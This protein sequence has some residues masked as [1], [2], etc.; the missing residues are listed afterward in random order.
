M[1]KGVK[2]KYKQYQY[3]KMLSG[4]TPIFSQF[5]DDIY[6][7]DIVKN[8]IRI[9]ATEISKLQPKQIR[10]ET[11]NQIIV[12]N[13]INRL[14]KFSPNPLMTTSEFL[15]KCVWL[16]EK[17]YN[18]FIYPMYYVGENNKRQY[19]GL[20]PLNPNLVEFLEDNAHTLFVKMHFN[21]GEH[22]TLPY[23]DIIHWRKDF[24]FN[25]VMGGDINGRPDNK[26]LLKV[27]K[28]NNTITEGLDKAVKTSLNVRGILKIKTLLSDENQEKEIKKF[29]QLLKNADTAILPMDLKGEYIPVDINPQIISKDTLEFV[30][31]KVLNN[32]GISLAIYNGDFTEEQYQAFYEKKIEPMII[33]LGQCFSKT[34]L[35]SREIDVGNEI[36]FYPQKLLFTNTANKIAVADILGNRGALTDNELL[37]LF[38][39]P[40]FEGGETRHQSLNYINRD[41]AD[42]YQMKNRKEE[43]GIE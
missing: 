30:E 7:S 20:Y 31:K 24:S 22:Y 6:T 35:T 34:L 1:F 23:E 18:C 41:I 15:G 25:D 32:Y 19:T 11:D 16:R 12:N 3:S 40:P 10:F 5:G 39:Y 42:Q 8:C 33:S 4:M 21:N 17:T 14:L 2:N 38:G 43:K 28:I 29:E 27:L 37:E 13:S 9:I 26:E 36:I